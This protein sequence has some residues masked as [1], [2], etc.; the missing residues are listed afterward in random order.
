MAQQ[1]SQYSGTLGERLR[2]RREHK[3]YGIIDVAHVLKTVPEYVQALE[4]DRYDVFSAKVYAL[5]F[6]KKMLA[7][8]GMEDS[9]HLLM[10]HQEW[11]VYARRN[12]RETAALPEESERRVFIITPL[13]I[14]WAFAGVVLIFFF[15]FLGVEL[16]HFAAAPRFM[17]NHPSDGIILDQPTLE[18]D[19]AAEKESSL[20]VNGRELRI[21]E[22]GRVH[23]QI[24]L[25]PG[26]NELVF[27]AQ[28]KFG[29]T[30]TL[31]R[32]VVV[33]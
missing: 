33:R 1:E 29:K 14:A 2:N 24:E 32:H 31:T 17:L 28:N 30:T 22:D 23:E 13:Y 8:L 11:D 4:E 27:V 20:T 7:L 21:D 25:Q 26:L 18:V 16:F 10:F 6:L 19:G 9:E 15:L 12:R 3:G 5:G